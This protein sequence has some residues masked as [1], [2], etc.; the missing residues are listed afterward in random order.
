MKKFYLWVM[1]LLCLML[2]GC[3]S[4]SSYEEGTKTLTLAVLQSESQLHSSNLTKWV[5]TYNKTHKDVQIEIVNYYDGYSELDEC[6]NRIKIEINAGKG[7][8]MI[9]FGGLYSPIDASCGM[10]TD[11]YPFIQNDDSFKNQDFYFNIL[12][13]FEVSGSLYVVVPNYSIG[14][15]A[16]IN[17][18]LR[19]LEMM[20]IQQLIAAYNRLDEGGILFPGETKKAVLGMLCHGSLDN[21]I[22]WDKGTCSFSSENFKEILRFSNGF[23]LHLNITEEYSAKQIFTEGRALL[24]PVSINNV[25]T[26]T[27]IRLIYGKTPTYIGYPFDEGYGSIAAIEDIAIGISSTSKNK[28]EAWKFIRS[29]LD[30]EFQDNVKNGLPV[31]VSSLELRIEDAMNAE[32]DEMGEMIAKSYLRFEGEDPVDIYEISTEDAETLKAIIGRIEFN[33]AIDNNLYNIMLEEASYLFHED[34]NVDDVAD[35]I[36]NRVSIYISERK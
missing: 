30:S 14:S 35:I 34:R 21:Y 24:Y 8:D 15:F 26:L 12:E 36:Q 22:D 9:N 20:N 29:L 2:V 11:L 33:E 10:M 1:G 5:N 7:P 17:E 16:T 6:I 31:R 3:G 28:E 4:K 27:G 23:P 18:E 19:D 25:Y 13:S 32:Y